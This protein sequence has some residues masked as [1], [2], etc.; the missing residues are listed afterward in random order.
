MAEIIMA[1]IKTKLALPPD[2]ILKAAIG[3]LSEVIIIGYDKD[4]EFYLASSEANK[5]DVIWLLVAAG[6]EVL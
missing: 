1:D 5:K 4:G 3:K 2:R 6:K